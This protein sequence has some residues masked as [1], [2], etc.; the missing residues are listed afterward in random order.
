MATGEAPL[1]KASC[2][3]LLEAERCSTANRRRRRHAHIKYAVTRAASHLPTTLPPP[4]TYRLACVS[5]RYNLEILPVLEAYVARQCAEN[6]Y[7]LDANLAVLKLY[8][9]HP[10]QNNVSVVAKI[11]IKALTN[12]PSADFLLCTYLIPERVVRAPH[13]A[14]T[15][16]RGAHLETVCAQQETEIIASI[17]ALATLLETCAFRQ[18]WV[19][20]R[21]TPL[22]LRRLMCTL[23]HVT[24]L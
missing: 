24:M 22:P 5:N 3:D 8:Q 19:A 12:L 17:S 16:T 2:A 15:S 1:D 10:E 18:V 23:L 4:P 14:H 11:L 9:F 7:D 13:V 21:A 20:V 6:T